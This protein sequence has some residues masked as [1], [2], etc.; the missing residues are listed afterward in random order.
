MTPSENQRSR[1]RALA[2]AG[3]AALLS[4]TIGCG[5]GGPR[6]GYA[7]ACAT[8]MSSLL[9]C[10]PMGWDGTGESSILEA[11][12]RLVTC[13][14]LASSNPTEEEGSSCFSD[15]DCDESRDGR[16]KASGSGPA[17]RC[18]YPWL[19]LRW[20]VR[21]LSQ[22]GADPCSTGRS[23]SVSQVALATTC[24]ADTP[25]EALGLSFSEKM[26]P[27]D[28]RPALDFATCR[29]SP[30]RIATATVCDQGLLQY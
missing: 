26:L 21:R 29:S 13:G 30:T 22:P 20:C 25:C 10:D 1:G 9:E 6:P 14:V 16:C 15:G 18:A 28:A 11:C 12:R 24:I 2:G 5:G 19:D 27:E 3:L 17:D 4:T 8:N 7:E 23:F